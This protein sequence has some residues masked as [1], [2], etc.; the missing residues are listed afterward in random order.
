MKNPS[1][2]C[3]CKSHTTTS[4]MPDEIQF[5]LSNPSNRPDSASR[6]RAHAHAAR[7]AHAKRSRFRLVNYHAGKSKTTVLK[8]QGPTIRQADGCGI[9]DAI[10]AE[11]ASGPKSLLSSARNDPFNS[12]AR[13]FTKAEHFLLD[14]C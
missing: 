4:E 10:V 2:H 7:V 13:T 11:N 14:H 9:A 12:L 8:D 1:A 3:D 6:K 5:I